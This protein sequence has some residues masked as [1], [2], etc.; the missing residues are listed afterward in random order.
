[1]NG[2]KDSSL[3]KKL[4]IGGGVI[5]AALGIYSV[6]KYFMKSSSATSPVKTKTTFK[7]KTKT[8]F[9][10][11]IVPTAK[12]NDTF[13]L[14]IGSNGPRVVKVQDALDKLGLKVNRSGTF[15]LD[16]TQKLNT[17]GFPSKLDEGNYI[18]LLT[19][20]D[21]SP[22]NI[23]L[24]PKLISDELLFA[25]NSGNLDLTIQALRKIKDTQGYEAV[26]K[27]F[28]KNKV[29]S[30]NEFIP[31]SVSVSSIVN[32]LLEI[33]FN[34]DTQAKKEI[35]AEFKRMGLKKNEASGSWSLTGLMDGKATVYTTTPT[36]I[37]DSVNIRTPVAKGRKLGMMQSIKNNM[38]FF[39][40]SQGKAFAVPYNTIRYEV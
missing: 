39:K 8:A 17:V 5:A 29:L 4:L 32:A 31:R 16:T 25:A 34:N 11:H 6:T 15:D 13:P 37:I 21:I 38:V 36:V 14:T 3:K 10:A 30:K 20:A 26:K 19:K 7:Q 23:I 33:V 28:I 18:A 9:V 35:E 1:L 24:N 27:E 12:L 2:F 22:L 40:D